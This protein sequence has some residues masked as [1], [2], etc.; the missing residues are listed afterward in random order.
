MKT[1][2]EIQ[3]DVMDELKWQPILNATEIGVAVKKGIVTLTGTVNSYA[4][5]L[6]AEKAAKIVLGVKAVVEDIKVKFFSTFQ[7]TD[8]EIAEA[9]LNSLKWDSSVREEKVKIKVEDGWVTLDGEVEWEYE[10]TRAKS[11]VEGLHGVRGITNLILVTPKITPNE[12]KKKIELAFHRSASLDAEHIKINT[13]GSRVTLTGTVR[14][15][16]EKKDAEDAAWAAPGV[17]VVEDKLEVNY[18]EALAY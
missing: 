15:L 16:A 3:R 8:I 10:K 18:A 7:K 12:L 9:V 17:S 13:T 1:D 5:K 4:K 11:C 2:Y 14:S 6:A